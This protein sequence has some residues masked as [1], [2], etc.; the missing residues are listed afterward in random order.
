MSC[1]ITLPNRISCII[2]HLIWTWQKSPT[3]T[4]TVAKQEKILRLDLFISCNFQQ[5]WFSCQKRHPKGAKR[6]ILRLDLSISCNFQQLWFSWQK[7]PPPFSPFHERPGLHHTCG[8]P[9]APIL[10]IHTQISPIRISS[11]G[12]QLCQLF[13]ILTYRDVQ[14]TVSWCRWKACQQPNHNTH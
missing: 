8:I 14:N 3:P 6:K 9:M 7:S 10:Q 4:P 1:D 11:L 2:E 13:K 5:H 12:Y